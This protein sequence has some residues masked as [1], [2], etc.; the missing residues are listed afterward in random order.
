MAKK[1]T[2]VEQMVAVS[3]QRHKMGSSRCKAGSGAITKKHVKLRTIL[4]DVHFLRSCSWQ[5]AVHVCSTGL[6]Q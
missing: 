1:Y 5:Y 4:G 6:V 2:K 3:M